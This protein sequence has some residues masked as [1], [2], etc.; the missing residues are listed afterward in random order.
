MGYS[1]SF[2]VSENGKED[3]GWCRVRLPFAAFLATRR[4]KTVP[5]APPLSSSPS[6]SSIVSVQ[7]MLSKFEYDGALNPVFEPGP[8]CLQIKEIKGYV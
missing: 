3:E 8:F 2:T 6:S 4:A 1:K 5:G 7:L